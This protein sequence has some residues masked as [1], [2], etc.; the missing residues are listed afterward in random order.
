MIWGVTSRIAAYPRPSRS[1]TPGRKFSTRTSDFLARDRT[2]PLPRG[3][4]RFT[5]TLFFPRFTLKKYELTSLTKGKFFREV[6]PPSGFSTLI[7]SAP[8]SERSIVQN[9]PAKAQVIS[10][11]LTFS[12]G[13]AINTP[14][15]T[16]SRIEIHG[17]EC[18]SENKSASEF[19]HRLFPLT[20]GNSVNFSQKCFA[21]QRKS[22][23]RKNSQIFFCD[24][25]IHFL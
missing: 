11:T 3:C 17:T 4:C 1:I 18:G 20:Q 22:A 14:L 15:S 23:W 16:E 21:R 7:T 9:G 6:S 25:Y 19:Y 2:I 5:V 13:P 10:R 8:K 24:N 12:K